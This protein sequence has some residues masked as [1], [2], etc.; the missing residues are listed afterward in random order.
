MKIRIATHT[1][2]PEMAELLHELFAI[3]VD[4]TPDYLT[5]AKGLELLLN[6]ESARIFVAEVEGSVVG[7]C[8]VQ[9]HISTAKGCEVG[10][11]EDVVVGIGHRN[12]GIGR[13]LLKAA[14]EWAVAH[15][16]ARLQLQADK[17]NGP[18]LAFYRCLGWQP[19][20]L[21]GW[22]KHL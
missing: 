3:E 6:R 7:M 20:Q 12:N 2:I 18:A 9:T 21:V 11:I 10:T 13:A 17:T 1:D 8:S 5:Q 14:E 16:L 22:M 4:F 19:T 15:N